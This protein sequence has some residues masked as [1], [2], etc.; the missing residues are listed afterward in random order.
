MSPADRWHDDLGHLV[1]VPAPPR[2]VV[3]L[4]PSLTEAIALSAPGVL[5]GA[6][7]WC[8]HPVDLDVVRVGGTKNPDLRRIIELAPDLVVANEEENRKPDVEALREN[9]IAVWVTDVRSVDSALT[10]LGRLLEVLGAPHRHWL[11][12]ARAAWAPQPQT[13]PSPSGP[14]RRTAVVAV[15]RRPWM[16]LG[17]DT[18]AGDVLRRV[19][20]DNA[21]AGH[22][23][24]YPRIDPADLP[25]HELVVLPDEP[26]R[27]TVDDGPEAFPDKAI[28]LVDGQ[29]LT[30]Y[31][32]RMIGALPML[33]AA[34]GQVTVEGN[35]R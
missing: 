29:A 6:T 26:Y 32:P 17:S 10:C 7:D 3:S 33:R 20:V 31:G 23:Q 9:G 35:E 1:A 16:W 5:V 14:V 12:Q 28:A 25:D 15:W 11:A 22:S 19:G 24:R 13:L 30:W 27:F 21:L 8:V 34:L 18:Y 4:V 2:R